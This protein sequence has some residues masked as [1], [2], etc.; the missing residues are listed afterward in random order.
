MKFYDKERSFF[1]HFEFGSY[2]AVYVLFYTWL[3]NFL[4]IILFDFFNYDNSIREIMAF[5][6]LYPG[7]LFFKFVFF[8]FYLI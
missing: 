1:N 2:I 4:I 7:Y 5:G 8:I 3:L 6:I